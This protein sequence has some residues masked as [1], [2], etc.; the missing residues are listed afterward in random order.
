VNRFR[1]RL[2]N[3]LRLRGVEEEKKKREFGTA[4]GYYNREVLDLKRIT[5]DIDEHE[6]I[7]E[8]HGQG[9]VSAHVLQ[10]NFYFIRALDEKAEKQKRKVK[11]KEKI[12]EKKRA[13]LAQSTKRKKIIERLKNRDREEYNRAVIKEEQALID[14]LTT[15]RYNRPET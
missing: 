9:K 11:E 14:E 6:R 13:E 1:F 15:Q 5:G 10:R 4:L 8:E 12:M 3:L 2:E 7:F